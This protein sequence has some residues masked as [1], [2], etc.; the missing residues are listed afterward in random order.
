MATLCRSI[1]NWTA[2]QKSVSVSFRVRRN[3]GPSTITVRCGPNKIA[4]FSGNAWHREMEHI[5]LPKKLCCKKRT[6]R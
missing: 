6:A 5:T 1:S 3:Y 2:M 4:A